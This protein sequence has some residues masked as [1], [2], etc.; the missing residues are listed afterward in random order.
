[1]MSLPLLPWTISAPAPAAMT[2]D[3]DVPS[4]ESSPGVPTI[5]AV[6]PWHLFGVDAKAV[7]VAPKCIAL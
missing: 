6:C 1:M 5:V 3:P 4:I 2:S 7:P